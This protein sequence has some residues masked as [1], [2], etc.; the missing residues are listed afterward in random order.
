MNCSKSYDRA[1][2]VPS[3]YYNNLYFDT[4]IYSNIYRQTQ[5]GIFIHFLEN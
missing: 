2:S 1:P 5:Y 3:T 4:D